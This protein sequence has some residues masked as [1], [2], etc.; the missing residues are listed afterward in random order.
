MF[1]TASVL[2]L[3]VS[4]V[5]SPEGTFLRKFQSENESAVIR[6]VLSSG[7]SPNW[8]RYQV[9]WVGVPVISVGSTLIMIST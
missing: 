9:A 8:A 4:T 1:L 3:S 7:Q 5:N 6:G 2:V